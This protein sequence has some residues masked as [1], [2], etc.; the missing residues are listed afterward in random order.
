MNTEPETER[1]AVV[2]LMG[3]MRA[4]GR[5]S[6]DTLLGTAMLRLDSPVG[7]GFATQLINPS[8]IYRMHFVEESIARAVAAGQSSSKP[9]YQWEIASLMP[10]KNEEEGDEY[11]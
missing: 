2:E 1:W 4:A 3:H 6:K 9:V 7:D 10:P 11:P 8:S 5:V